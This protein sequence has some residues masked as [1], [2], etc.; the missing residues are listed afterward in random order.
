MASTQVRAV[1]RNVPMSPRK[2]R[3]VAD[4]VRGKPVA[5]ALG[6]LRFLPQR[7]AEAVASAVKSAAANAENN[8]QLDP[9]ELVI[10]A[11]TADEG[12]RLKRFR[13]RARGRVNRIIKR[14]SHITVVVAEKEA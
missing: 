7:A 10:V 6:L 5:Q 4:V 3:L 2:V 9:E 12:R 1:A 14:S 11:I 13:P 8:F